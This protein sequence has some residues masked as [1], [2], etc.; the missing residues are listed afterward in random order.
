M[1]ERFRFAPPQPKTA[2]VAAAA[3]AQVRGLIRARR[4][5]DQFFRNELFADPAWGMPLDLMAERL[6]HKPASLP[7]LCIAAALHHTTPP[8]AIPC[9]TDIGLFVL[10]AASNTGG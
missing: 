5:R 8:S 10:Q 1:P 6:A 9:L 7:S 4:T 2:A 3:G